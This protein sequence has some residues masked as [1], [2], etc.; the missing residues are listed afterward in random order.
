MA[1]DRYVGQIVGEV[2]DFCRI[3]EDEFMS[4]GDY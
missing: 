2:N 1:P 4:K 3:L